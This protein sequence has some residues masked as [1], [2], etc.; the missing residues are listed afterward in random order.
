MGLKNEFYTVSIKYTLH[1]VPH[2]NRT[3]RENEFLDGRVESSVH[4]LYFSDDKSSHYA[5]NTQYTS[6]LFVL[7]F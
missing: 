1:K 7:I 6:R 3:S 5:L 2:I 4:K